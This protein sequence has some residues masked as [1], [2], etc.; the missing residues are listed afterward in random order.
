MKAPLYLT[1]FPLLK[2]KFHIYILNKGFQDEEEGQ[3]L[4]GGEG[5]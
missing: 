1:R 4:D 3:E 5:C 2:I